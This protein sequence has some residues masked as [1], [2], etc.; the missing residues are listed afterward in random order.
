MTSP[1]K[2]P[3]DPDDPLGNLDGIDDYG[4]WKDDEDEDED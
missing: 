3:W 4:H 2:D 1:G